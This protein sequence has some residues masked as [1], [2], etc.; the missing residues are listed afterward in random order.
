MLHEYS[1]ASLATLHLIYEPNLCFIRALETA[2]TVLSF[3]SLAQQIRHILWHIDIP[4][5]I[6]KLLICLYIP[7]VL[8][9]V[10]FNL[11]ILAIILST[12]KLRADPRNSFIVTLAFSDFFLCCFTSPLTLWSILEGHWPLGENTGTVQPAY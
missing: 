10:V 12:A 5:S 3:S 4:A 7:I 6:Y 1:L 9:G 11:I 2:L 8:A